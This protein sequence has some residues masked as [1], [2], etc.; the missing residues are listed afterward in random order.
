MAGAANAF[1]LTHL[2]GQT[3]EELA[4]KINRYRQARRKA[5]H[6]GDG[7]VTLML[8]TFIGDSEPQVSDTVRGPLTAYLGTAAALVRQAASAFPAFKRRV[9]SGADADSAF[10]SLTPEEM[11]GLLAFAVE[12]YYRTSG[13]FGTVEDALDMVRRVR[14]AGVDEIA[15]LIDFGIDSATVLAHL[16]HLNEL[17][18]AATRAVAGAG[19]R[20]SYAASALIARHGVTH[21]QCTPSQ[22]RMWLADPEM[23]EAL[24]R[25]QCLLVGGEALPPD[26]AAELKELLGAAPI[27]N[28]YGPTETTIW[29]SAHALDPTVD[30]SVPIGTPLANTRLYVLDAARQLVPIGLPG[31]LWIGG[32]AVTRGYLNRPELTAERFVPDP[33]ASVRDA[34]MYRTGDLVRYRAD[35]VLEFLGRLDHQ[36]KIQGHRIELGEIEARLLADPRVREAVVAARDDSGHQRLVA[37]VVPDGSARADGPS[38]A[39][40][41]K[42]S[43]RDHLPAFMIPAQLVV[44]DALPRTPNGKIDR[45]GLPAPAAQLPI[46]TALAG[47]SSESGNELERLIASVWCDVL[48]QSSVGMRDNFF[49]LGGDSLLAVQAH[50]RL[51][52]V[53]PALV[54]TDLFRY[55]T[56]RTL[57]EHLAGPEAAGPSVAQS[58]DRGAL[59]RQRFQRRQVV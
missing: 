51:R 6:A 27:L 49:D 14:E 29:S 59:R 37:Y 24:G 56:V 52:D 18:D 13:L 34:R 12:R 22:A 38:L 15:C 17:K 46:G 10:K 25:V 1:L 9:D 21:V 42:D 44:L 5:G 50:R 8:H 3:V 2:L 33:F 53:A 19:A 48:G 26:L 54:L 36:V 58:Q 30:A 16:T 45:K 28:M 35:G 4:D 43:L 23:R 20:V 32:S 41:L 40:A 57:A 55:P 11:D 31:E 47:A 39:A 7:Y